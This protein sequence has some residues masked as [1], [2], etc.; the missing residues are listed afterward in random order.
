MSEQRKS[1]NDRR[2]I[3]RVSSPH[4]RLHLKQIR[5]SLLILTI[6]S[7]ASALYFFST[8]NGVT[9]ISYGV[10]VG[11]MFLVISSLIWRY[12]KSILLFVE[13]ESASNLDSTMEKQSTLW[14]AI[15][16]F[17]IVY[18]ISYFLFRTKQ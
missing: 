18:T 2:I 4:M 11:I 3:E 14:M 5:W 17:S 8:G 1:A 9:E 7:G 16:F 10:F 15:T 12:Y 13:N 6:V